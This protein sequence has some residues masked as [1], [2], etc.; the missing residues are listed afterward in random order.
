V[1]PLTGGGQPSK[2]LWH[3]GLRTFQH[4][5]TIEIGNGGS[6]R[7]REAADRVRLWLFLTMFKMRDGVA[8]QPGQLRKLANT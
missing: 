2:L 8:S 5:E 3:T 6:Q 4:W 1:N 7:H